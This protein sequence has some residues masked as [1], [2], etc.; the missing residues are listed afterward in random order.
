MSTTSKKIIHHRLLVIEVLLLYGLLAHAEDPLLTGTPIGSSPS[1]TYPSGAASTTQNLPADAFDGNLATYYASYDR[2]YTWVGLDLGSEHIITRVGWSPRNDGVGPARTRL[3]LFEG[4]NQPD[5]SDAMPLYLTDASGTIGVI[6]T[7]TVNVSKGFRYVRYVGPSDSRCN[8]AEVQ[9]FGHPGTGDYSELYLPSGLPVVTIHIENNRDPYDK[10][11]DLQSVVTII[12]ADGSLLRDSAGIR[13]RGNASMQFAKKPYRIKFHSKHKVPGSPAKAKKWT[14]LN[15]YG[16]K[17]LMRNMVAFDYSRRLRM[18][19][20]PFCIPV[21][22]FVNGEYKGC[23]QLAD[24][25]DIRPG[26]VDIDEMTP[27]DEAGL[28]LTD[29][30]FIELDGYADKEPEKARFFTTRYGMG[31]TIKSP[32][33]DSITAF[34]KTYIQSYYNMLENLVAAANHTD[35]VTGWRSML[36]EDSFLKHFLIGELTGNT[37]TYW[38]CH[39]Y[40]R[41]GDDLLYTGPEWDFDIAFDNDYRHYPTCNKSDYVYVYAGTY[42]SFVNRII[43]QDAGTTMSLKRLWSTVRL[44]DGLTA[45]NICNLIDSLA[46]A[47]NTSQ[48]LNFL[49]WPILSKNVHMNPRNAGSYDGEVTFLKNYV[50]SRIAWM[51]NKIGLDPDMVEQEQ[52]TD[53]DEVI[54][55]RQSRPQKI[56][57][58]GTLYIILPNGTT[59][60]STGNR[61]E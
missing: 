1:V 20:T 21:D 27:R 46:A 59:Y 35:P 13:L 48:R 56:L 23:Y 28:A 12:G 44:R 53:A 7:A 61:I 31:V 33:Q 5:F 17:T 11:N 19:Y 39:M 41:R 49:R 30:Y 36:D 2:S 60:D 18:T 57:R 47:M 6:S 45:D 25:L 54:N 26:R 43:K 16:D 14:L 38:S 8:V 10:V 22:V 52:P 15:N 29:G 58:E 24:Q 9:F 34:Q 32:D 42:A 50:R 40:K 51:D 3:A 55:T 4:A 37:D